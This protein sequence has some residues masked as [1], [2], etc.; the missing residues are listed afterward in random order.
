MAERIGLPEVLDQLAPLRDL[1][2]SALA[3]EVVDLAC[4]FFALLGVYEDERR[5][6]GKL[7]EADEFIAGLLRAA[8]V[9]RAEGDELNLEDLREAGDRCVRMAAALGAAAEE[10]LGRRVWID[11]GL[12]GLPVVMVGGR[13]G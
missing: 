3:E 6:S 9:L 5:D 4:G 8:D 7:P 1:G 2:E 11:A 12:D 13:H 10:G